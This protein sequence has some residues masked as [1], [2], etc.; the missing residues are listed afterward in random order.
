MFWCLGPGVVSTTAAPEERVFV[1][2]IVVT[3]VKFWGGGAGRENQQPA[4]QLR[5]SLAD[6]GLEKW[7]H[8]PMVV[9]AEDT[10]PGII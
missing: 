3:S 6:N 5:N 9:F 4:F 1:K 8:G 2:F 10:G 7:Q